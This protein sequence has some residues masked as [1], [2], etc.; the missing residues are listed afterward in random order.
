MT[1]REHY[2][3]EK[4]IKL[5]LRGK[6]VPRNISHLGGIA[7]SPCHLLETLPTLVFHPVS[8]SEASRTTLILS[9]KV[10]TDLSLS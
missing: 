2:S 5:C 4:L 7:Q 10:K 1:L 6:H 8:N 9:S 3:T